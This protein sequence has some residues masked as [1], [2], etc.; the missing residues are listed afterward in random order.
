MIT[1]PMATFRNGSI[2]RDEMHVV[3]LWAPVPTSLRH[4]PPI[5]LYLDE[6]PLFAF[7]PIFAMRF[8]FRA[9]TRCSELLLR[10]RQQLRSKLF[11]QAW[12][13]PIHIYLPRV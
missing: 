5:G 1:A 12:A 3:V 11:E 10:F 2:V 8:F 7:A 6:A 13:R 9:S 4:W